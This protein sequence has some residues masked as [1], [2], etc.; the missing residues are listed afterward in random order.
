MERGCS[1]Q[2]VLSP[3]ACRSRTPG[4][5]A[6]H[7]RPR[8]SRNHRTP[9]GQPSETGDDYGAGAQTTSLPISDPVMHITRS[10]HC[11]AARWDFRGSSRLV[12][13]RRVRITIATFSRLSIG[14][15]VVR[16]VAQTKERGHSRMIVHRLA[17]LALVTA[18]FV[19]FLA[20]P[21]A[22]AD[23]LMPFSATFAETFTIFTGPSCPANA[24]CAAATG[25]GHATHLGR[26]TE[27]CT[28]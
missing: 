9:G 11:R 17:G 5:T 24:L 28:G 27:S 19:L 22:F 3:D 15:D 18:L 1:R 20:V 14:R 10:G 12:T 16:S 6:S 4:A 7:H 2:P 26:T 23:E 13:S 25:V 8:P 21:L